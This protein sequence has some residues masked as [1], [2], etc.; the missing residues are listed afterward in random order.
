MKKSELKKL[1]KE[2]INESIKKDTKVASDYVYKI[3]DM[4]ADLDD[5]SKEL[6]NNRSSVGFTI[7]SDPK[8]ASQRNKLYK[9]MQNT[10]NEIDKLSMMFL[11][12]NG[13]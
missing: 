2:A 9:S 10:F 7:N 1:V 5:V 3:M 13:K 12:I 11:K 4:W 6:N 8:L